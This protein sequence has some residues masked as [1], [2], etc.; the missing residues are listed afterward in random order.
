MVP[1]LHSLKVRL[2]T[3]SI[4]ITILA[5]GMGYGVFLIVEK[6]Q[7]IEFDTMRER[8]FVFFFLFILLSTILNLCILPVVLHPVRRLTQRL[9][10]FVEDG[11]V[12]GKINPADYPEM[13]DLVEATMEFVSSVEREKSVASMMRQV[14]R[15]RAMMAEKD[16]MTGLYN[17]SYLMAMVNSELSRSK[18]LGDQ[19]S[20]VMLDIDNFK[21]YNDTNG[22]P[23]GDQVLI[24]IANILRQNTR[25]LDLCARFGGEEF[26]VVLP[27][28]PLRIAQQIAERIRRTIQKASFPYED[29]QPLGSLTASFGVGCFPEH[30]ST[31][32]ELIRKADVALYAAKRS[33]KNRVCV[34]AES[35]EEEV[36]PTTELGN[37][38]TE[39]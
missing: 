36:S 13:R 9:R 14:T 3:C 17:K 15:K 30:A 7:V 16:P 29:K 38:P 28:T 25:D 26:M 10:S 24:E 31:A 32:E 20:L 35:F 5:A 39:S 19:L 33:G 37:P 21:H 23:A 22:H 6:A 27:K 2:V 12:V 8:L 18:V 34:Y 4:L 1:G 11:S